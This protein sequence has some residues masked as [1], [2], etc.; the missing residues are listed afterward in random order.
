MCLS[1]YPLFWRSCLSIFFV[2][3]MLILLLVVRSPFWLIITWNVFIGS[4]LF[5]IDY[6]GPG[7]FILIIQV[8]FFFRYLTNLFCSEKCFQNVSG[9]R[10]NRSKMTILKRG[11]DGFSYFSLTNYFIF[12]PRSSL[13]IAKNIFS[14]NCIT[15]NTQT[16]KSH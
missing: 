15:K 3:F 13:I 5:Y 6:S 7:C 16:F 2:L 9:H 8:G 10:Q 12:L 11:V 14:G 4:W 1:R